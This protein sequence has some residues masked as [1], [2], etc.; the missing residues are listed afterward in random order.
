MFLVLPSEPLSTSRDYEF[1]FHHSGTVIFDAAF[2]F[3]LYGDIQGSNDKVGD[4]LLLGIQSPAVLEGTLN[5]TRILYPPQAQVVEF[6]NN[7]DTDRVMSEVQGDPRRAKLGAT[8]LLTL[9]N[10]PMIYYG[11]EIGMQG[12]K[13]DEDIRLPMQWS[14][15]ANAGFTTGT[16]TADA[17]AFAFL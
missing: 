17:D 4:S 16:G 1:E 7:H 10:T 12:V 14:A 3:P 11:E 9:P 6:I 2:D 5:A 15:D 8:L 13:P